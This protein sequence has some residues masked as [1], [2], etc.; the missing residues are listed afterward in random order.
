M[1]QSI[2]KMKQ[3]STNRLVI[4]MIL[5]SLSKYFFIYSQPYTG[6]SFQSTIFLQGNYY[7][8]PDE[9]FTYNQTS[10]LPVF[11]IYRSGNL[12]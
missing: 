7:H 8:E 5:M 12:T 3:Y 2:M 11:S 4:G 9:L 6:V 1:L 10:L